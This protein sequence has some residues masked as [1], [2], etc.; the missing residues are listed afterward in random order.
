MSLAGHTQSAN[1][2]HSTGHAWCF[3]G[4]GIVG[5]ERTDAQGPLRG[6]FSHHTSRFHLVNLTLTLP[7]PLTFDWAA[8]GQYSCLVLVGTLLQMMS[9]VWLAPVPSP[10]RTFPTES[11]RSD[12]RRAGGVSNPGSNCRP[13]SRLFRRLRFEISVR[14]QQCCAPLHARSLVRRLLS[15][16]QKTSRDFRVATYHIWTFFDSTSWIFTNTEVQKQ[17][18]QNRMHGTKRERDAIN[19]AL[20]QGRHMTCAT[21][22]HKIWWHPPLILL[23]GIVI[24]GQGPP[25]H[26]EQ[27]AD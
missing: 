27:S 5:W 12:T 25:A 21:R 18:S 10:R 26:G 13:H 24:F 14:D 8:Q 19:S 15:C 17:L 11:V 4:E 22:H 3:R 7:T 2:R 16:P 23:L 1:G 9:P 6:Y 20:R